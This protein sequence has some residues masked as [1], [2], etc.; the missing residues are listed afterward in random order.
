M[1][2]EYNLRFGR[3]AIVPVTETADRRVVKVK[4]FGERI[5][6][7]VFTFLTRRSLPTRAGAYPAVCP[8]PLASPL[9][10]GALDPAGSLGIT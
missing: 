1:I 2:N 10:R 3:L 9:S 4:F 8:G 6:C 5:R 7:Y